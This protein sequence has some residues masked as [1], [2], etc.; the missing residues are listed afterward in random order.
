MNVQV[1]E[2]VTKYQGTGKICKSVQ[3]YNT[4]MRYL[5]SIIVFEHFQRP[6]VAEN[7]TLQEFISAR[8]ATD[9]RTII[10]VADHKTKY[11]GPA[12]IA[13]EPDHHKLFDL[14]AKRSVC[15]LL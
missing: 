11:S 8:K 7:L 15:N 14:Y 13:L 3:D 12:Q 5:I 6:S 1:N 4:L 2:L 10:L 9:G